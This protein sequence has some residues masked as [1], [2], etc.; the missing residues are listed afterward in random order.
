MTFKDL[1]AHF[2]QGT[3]ASL[4]VEDIEL[5]KLPELFGFV[6]DLLTEA[7]IEDGTAI[8]DAF[9]EGWVPAADLRLDYVELHR[10]TD[11]A[12]AGFAGELSWNDAALTVVPDVLTVENIVVSI[13]V[14]GGTVAIQLSGTLEIEGYHLLATVGLP[15]LYL[16]ARLMNSSPEADRPSPF[17][18]L[19]RF[20]AAPGPAPTDPAH[21]PQ[22]DGLL[23]M[24]RPNIGRVLFQL[25]LKQLTLGPV[26]MDLRTELSYTAGDVG[27]SL[28]ADFLIDIDDTRK[29]FLLLTGVHEGPGAG[30]QLEGGVA[31]SGINL[32]EL[33]TALK[34]HFD[35]T[36]GP[37]IPEALRGPSV[38]VKYLYLACDTATKSFT[39]RCSLDFHAIFSLPTDE[40]SG[41]AGEVDLNLDLEFSPH[42]EDGVEKHAVTFGGQVLFTLGEA[43]PAVPDDS[44]LQ[45]EFDLVFGKSG[46]ENTLVAAYRDLGGGQLP[47]GDL[48]QLFTSA[49][50]SALDFSIDI[51]QA[52]FISKSQKNTTTDKTEHHFI[53]GLDVGGGVDL[54][55]LPLVGNLM[56]H[57]ERLSI[58]LQPMYAS[59]AFTTD[60]LQEIQAIVPGGELALPDAIAAKGPEIT[61]ALNLGDKP[62]TLDLALAAADV[63]PESTAS[64]T[65]TA[66]AAA[67]AAQNSSDDGTQWIQLQ[68]SFGPISFERIGMKFADKKFW[69]KL[70]GALS[71][72]GLTLS[73]EGLGVGISLPDISP[74][75]TLSGL[76]LDF[77]KGDFEIG[78]SFLRVPGDPDE[79]SGMAVMKYGD[80]GLSAIGSYA[81][82]DG[83]PSLFL[84]AVLNY[85]IGGPSFFFV[86]GLA[87]G[88]GYNRALHVPPIDGIKDFPLVSLATAASG[89]SAPPAPTNQAER[90]SALTGVLTQL[91]DAIPP[92][93]GQYFIAAGIKFT[94]FKLID[95]FLLLSVSF[96]VHFE[97]NL[98]GLSTLQSPAPD[99]SGGAVK[100]LAVAQ[101][102]IRGTFQPDIGFLGVEARLTDAS[103]IFDEACHLT[104]GF[105]F[106]SWFSGEHEGDF[107][108]SLGGYHPKFKVP[109]HYPTVPRLGIDW[110]ISPSFSVRAEFYFALTA[111]ALMAGGHLKAAY[112]SGSVKAWFQAG[113][114][115][116]ISWKPYYYD[117]TFSVGVGVDVTIHFFGTHHLSFHLGADVHVW[118]PEFS[119]KAE[120]SL[121]V[122]TFTVTFGSG[123]TVAPYIS[124]EE[125]N[126]SFLPDP[127]KVCT[128]IVSEGRVNEEDSS[129]GKHTVVNAKELAI[130]IN[131]S[132]PI[133]N[134]ARVRSDL[135]A[136]TLVDGKEIAN[137]GLRSVLGGTSSQVTSRCRVT[138]NGPEHLNAFQVEPIFKKVPAAIWGAP[139]SS[140]PLAPPTKPDLNAARFVDHA[141]SGFTIRAIPPADAGHSQLIDR[142]NIAYSTHLVHDG[143]AYEQT[144]DFTPDTAV[145]NAKGYIND[146]LLDVNVVE[147]RKTVL[148]ALSF[149]PDA[150]DLDNHLADVF[151]EMPLVGDFI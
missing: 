150:L 31:L 9:P 47:I 96:G 127:E 106:Y 33:F 114:D 130:T 92:A 79:Y 23:I 41:Q 17:Q 57:A 90:A 65:S 100:P 28:W 117:A 81:Y 2:H 116:I 1:K 35:I 109:A 123:K 60:E 12:P 5:R 121:S 111:S 128:A 46:S 143:F 76:G 38:E 42:E 53:L 107:V 110:R 16:E 147:A 132:V 29:I 120:I 21:H 45:L 51:K 71:A 77:H 144:Q 135:V 27:G 43:D 34:T 6:D 126:N 139:L 85:P 86:T 66:P 99:I 131:T 102:A 148:D 49:D 97:I 62:L 75:F 22:L 137:I 98:L 56:P 83:H 37:E 61:V 104:G 39:F 124:W 68:K 26:T 32:V 19:E 18:L 73:L 67:P 63:N 10:K 50:V 94:S 82:Q 89:G 30:W 119:G 74:S 142:Q 103:Y 52:Y 70:D 58:N 95:S 78:G 151:T 122:I 149:P 25:G 134:A 138:I 101:L 36:A 133:A 118:G 8:A 93:N 4:V 44:P 55:G 59:G 112:H 15:G 146:H 11:T 64:T 80:L 115:F 84:Y 72:A 87:A 3:D 125:F 13:E 69:F 136:G 141:L 91:H 7:G 129:T 48:L 40:P 113:A 88:F 24:A 14:L 140:N 108:L 105:A 54:S 20:Q 145:T